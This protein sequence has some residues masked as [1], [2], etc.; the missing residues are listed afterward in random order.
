MRTLV[1]E[2]PRGVTGGLY[3]SGKGLDRVTSDCYLRTE[4]TSP[5]DLAADDVRRASLNEECEFYGAGTPDNA[6]Y[7]NSFGNEFALESPDAPWLIAASPRVIPDP[8]E[9]SNSK[10]I[11]TE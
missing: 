10:D 3:L 5:A 6:R 7:G 2:L 8:N 9:K 4:L 11:R 1:D